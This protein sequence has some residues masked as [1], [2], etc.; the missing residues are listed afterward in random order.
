MSDTSILIQSFTVYL[1]VALNGSI[2]FLSVVLSTSL[3]CS[4]LIL[5]V[6]E[7]SADWSVR[8]TTSGV[9]FQDCNLFKCNFR[10][11]LCGRIYLLRVDLC[12]DKRYEVFVCRSVVKVCW[13]VFN[14]CSHQPVEFSYVIVPLRPNLGV[15]DELEV[16]KIVVIE[17]VSRAKWEKWRWRSCER[18]ST[19]SLRWPE[20]PR[21]IRTCRQVVDALFH[22]AFVLLLVERLLAAV[23]NFFAFYL[24]LV[25]ERLFSIYFWNNL[26]LRTWFRTCSTCAAV[27]SL[28]VRL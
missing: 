8:L 2:R 19:S 25:F 17:S 1:T 11:A 20:M 7:D 15:G 12:L 16:C 22:I 3:I 5:G 24:F 18:P 10:V 21:R 13:W 4:S 27:T 14:L 26:E 28:S 6:H 9:W 23:L